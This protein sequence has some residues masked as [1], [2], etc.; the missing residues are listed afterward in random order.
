MILQ[1]LGKDVAEE[2]KEV[3]K[4]RDRREHKTA[5]R[6]QTIYARQGMSIY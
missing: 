5:E 6:G 1:E 2:L 3:E 4:G